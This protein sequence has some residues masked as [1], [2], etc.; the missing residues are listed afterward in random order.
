LIP[1]FAAASNM[2]LPSAISTV[3]L[4]MYTVVIS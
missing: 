3:C 4:L 2:V 1:A